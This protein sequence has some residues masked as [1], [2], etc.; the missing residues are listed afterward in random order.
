MTLTWHNGGIGAA[1][2]LGQLRGVVWAE[3]ALAKR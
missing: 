2:Q 3:V 1:L